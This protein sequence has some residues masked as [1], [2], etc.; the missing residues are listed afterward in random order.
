MLSSEAGEKTLLLFHCARQTMPGRTKVKVQGAEPLFDEGFS[1]T[2]I[3]LTQ[4]ST[5]LG[6]HKQR[7][8]E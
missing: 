5:T 2:F 8:C 3:G 1:D 7:V 4:Y 6:A